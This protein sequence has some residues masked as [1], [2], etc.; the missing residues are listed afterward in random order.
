MKASQ[1]A[2]DI[3]ARQIAAQGPAWGPLAATIRTGFTNL[4]VEPALKAIDEALRIG[5]Q[6]P[7]G[8]GTFPE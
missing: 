4:W 3:Y 7:D 1:Q 5:A 2:R 6:D 8:D